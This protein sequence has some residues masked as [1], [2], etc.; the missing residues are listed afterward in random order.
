MSVS[1][2]TAHVRP[3][4]PRVE[5]TEVVWRSRLVVDGVE[6]ELW[7]ARP[8]VDVPAEGAER[9]ALADAHLLGWLMHAMRAGLPVHVHGPV[10][11]RLLRGLEEWQE[12]WA[13]WR[14]EVYR[15]VAITADEVVEP[16]GPGPSDVVVAFSGGVD[17]SFTVHRHLTGAAGRRTVP[18]RTALM[19]HGFDVPLDR[20]D[21]FERAVHR[22]GLLLA[23][24]GLRLTTLRTNVRDHTVDWEDE[25]GL[26]LAAT[27]GLL[28]DEHGVGLI[29][30][31][32]SYDELE[33]PWGS[34]VI[35]DHHLSGA[36]EIRN[37]SSG[38]GRVAKIDALARWEAAT[39]HVRVCWK[40]VGAGANCGAC[41]KCL[42]T[43]VTFLLAGAPAVEA[44]PEIDPRRVAR[45]RMGGWIEWELWRLAT[46]EIRRRGLR[47]P[48]ARAAVWA[49]RRNRLLLPAESAVR[50]LVRGLRARR[51]AR[52]AI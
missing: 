36:L 41:P 25:H 48:W 39:R 6:R 16:A 23:G 50:P 2:H 43:H 42:R 8:A 31:S 22:A 44:F 33:V 45:V 40:Q 17:A 37:D 18:L 34:S 52:S 7:F 10:S 1:L 24:T 9:R 19:V 27:L 20:P 26:A 29:A 15:A 5:G 47:D 28:A 30:S 38:L 12:A 46:V 51:A 35:I 13:L 21:D 3:S 14:P 32:G 49:V 11:A 4:P